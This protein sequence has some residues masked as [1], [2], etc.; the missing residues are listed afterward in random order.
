M[1]VLFT[2]TFILL[3]MQFYISI[4]FF[5]YYSILLLIRTSIAGMKRAR[6]FTSTLQY[7]VR[8]KQEPTTEKL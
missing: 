8:R 6:N 1:L 3:R 2:L 5:F 7:D 4:S